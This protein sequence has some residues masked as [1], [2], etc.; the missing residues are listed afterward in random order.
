MPRAE[1][2][3]D[4]AAT[5]PFWAPS[6][7]PSGRELPSTRARLECM[8]VCNVVMW[9]PRIP[10][11]SCC[12]VRDR[13]APAPAPATAGIFE[14]A[15]KRCVLSSAILIY[16]LPSHQSTPVPLPVSLR[17]AQADPKES[18]RRWLGYIS[19]VCLGAGSPLSSGPWFLPTSHY[20]L[21]TLPLIDFRVQRCR[22]SHRS[23]T[24]TSQ[25][26]RS[27]RRRSQAPDPPRPSI[28]RRIHRHTSYQLHRLPRRRLPLSPRVRS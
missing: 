5:D 22:A 28:P 18:I 17:L 13:L 16:L 25:R 9:Q 21:H 3:P 26:C 27:A 2:V 10:P 7:P 4:L 14:D 15:C 24:R 8:Y 1:L 19:G 11:S 6:A 23:R 12:D 20:C